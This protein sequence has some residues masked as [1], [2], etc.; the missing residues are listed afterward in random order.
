MTA[1]AAK[2]WFLRN[3]KLVIAA[4]FLLSG[5]ASAA[6]FLLLPSPV[7]PGFG[8]A[9][10]ERSAR[11]CYWVVTGLVVLLSFAVGASM[12]PL[13]ELMAEVAFPVNE[14]TAANFWVLLVEIA[15]LLVP[16]ALPALPA[17]EAFQ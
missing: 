14:G 4:S 17:A 11:H 9:V 10:M 7:G 16:A 1:A 13:L 6:L 12:P 2:C 15:C 8:V 5:I 3:L